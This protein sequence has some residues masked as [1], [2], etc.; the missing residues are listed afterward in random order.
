MCYGSS[1]IVSCANFFF[2]FVDRTTIQSVNQPFVSHIV[3]NKAISLEKQQ[4]SRFRYTADNFIALFIQAQHMSQRTL[5]SIYNH[6][7]R[8]KKRRKQPLISLNFFRKTIQEKLE[9]N[10]VDDIFSH[11]PDA[12]HVSIHKM[13]QNWEEVQHY[14]KLNYFPYSHSSLEY[15]RRVYPSKFGS[16]LSKIATKSELLLSD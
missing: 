10:F 12:A 3:N 9:K 7:T 6:C 4:L 11:S 2:I 15:Y 1:T 16:S 13:S 5:H 14:F 8:T